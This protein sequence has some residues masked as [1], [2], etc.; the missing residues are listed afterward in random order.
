MKV[1]VREFYNVSRSDEFVLLPVGDVHIGSAAC[2]EERLAQNVKRIAEHDNFYWLGM[3]DYCEYINRSDPRFSTKCLA[4][5]VGINELDDLAK[6]QSVRF[7]EQV[8]PIAARGVRGNV[9]AN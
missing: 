8:Q 6:A 1:I 2:D 5:W 3:G 9:S 4:N 7:R